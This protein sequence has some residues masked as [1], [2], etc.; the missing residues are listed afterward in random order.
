MVVKSATKKKLMDLGFNE[1][2]A[3]TMANDRRWDDVKNM[4]PDQIYE[5]IQNHVGHM[6]YADKV[7]LWRKLGRLEIKVLKDDKGEVDTNQ[8]YISVP[9]LA[10]DD[11]FHGLYNFR[12]GVMVGE[13]DSFRGLGSLFS[14]QASIFDWHFTG[15][16]DKPLPPDVEGN[17]GYLTILNQLQTEQLTK[18][19]RK[20]ERAYSFPAAYASINRADILSLWPTPKEDKGGFDGLGSLFG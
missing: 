9:Y 16:D 15:A 13:H 3:N 11:E 2:M 6:R 7:A 18:I 20:L 12:T 1:P 17:D 5:I 14:T 19:L 4:S 8:V 10:G